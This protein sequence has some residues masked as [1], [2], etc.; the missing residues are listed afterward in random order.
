MLCRR[1]PCGHRRDESRCSTAMGIAR[2][3]FVQR[4]AAQSALQ[5]RIGFVMAKRCKAVR[6]R[7]KPGSF[8]GA[9]EG[10]QL[11]DLARWRVF[12][13]GMF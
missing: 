6:A 4:A 7:L 3:D 8:E 13:H 11:F 2:E 1:N 10:G 5:H 9:F 12:V